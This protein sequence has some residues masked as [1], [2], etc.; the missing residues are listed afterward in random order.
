MMHKKIKHCFRKIDED[1]NG[2]HFY[3]LLSK[4]FNDDIRNINDALYFV[5]DK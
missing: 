5:I 1:R 2:L 4:D 3:I